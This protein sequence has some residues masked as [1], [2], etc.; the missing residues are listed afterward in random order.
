LNEEEKT[1]EKGWQRRPFNKTQ[2]NLFSVDVRP[3]K[4]ITTESFNHKIA[5]LDYCELKSS[6]EKTRYFPQPSPPASTAIPKS[7]RIQTSTDKEHSMAANSWLMI[8]CAKMIAL[9][10][11]GIRIQRATPAVPLLA[12]DNAD[13]G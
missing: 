12:A 7:R 13:V 5:I 1:V 11:I 8:P 6:T 4:M 9:S 3:K 10:S 2:S